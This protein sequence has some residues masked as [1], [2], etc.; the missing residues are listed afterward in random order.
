MLKTFLEAANSIFHIL[1]HLVLKRGITKY[2]KTY[3]LQC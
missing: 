1:W 2:E 3:A